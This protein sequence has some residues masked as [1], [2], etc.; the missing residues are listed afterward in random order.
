MLTT[1]GEAL[2]T[3]SEYDTGPWLRPIV[4]AC[5]GRAGSTAVPRRRDTM[6]GANTLSRNAAASPIT[7]QRATKARVRSVAGDIGF[8]RDRPVGSTEDRSRFDC[9]VRGR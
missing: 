1:A 6:P 5:I 8:G 7:T 9:A 3:A 4:A 2:E